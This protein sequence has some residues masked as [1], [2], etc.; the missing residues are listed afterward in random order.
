MEGTS[1]QHAVEVQGHGGVVSVAKVGGLK[2]V[3][4]LLSM[5]LGALSLCT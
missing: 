1:G 5:W 4:D 3:V 2:S